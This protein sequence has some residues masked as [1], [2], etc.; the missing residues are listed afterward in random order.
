VNVSSV[1]LPAMPPEE[2]DALMA[3]LK[4]WCKAEHGRQKDLAAELDVTEQVLS[5]WIAGRK[6]PGLENYLK[7][8]A[9]LKHR[10]RGR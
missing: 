2:L 7:L 9:F 10:R 4:A 5:N 1:N 8:R 3:E 6:K